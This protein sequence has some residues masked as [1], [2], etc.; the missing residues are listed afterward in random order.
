MEKLLKQIKGIDNMD[1]MNKVIN[2]IK[3]QRKIVK[4]AQIASFKSKF[5]VGDD[6]K[7][8]SS[9]NA[10]FIEGTVKRVKRTR[11][12]VHVELEGNWDVPLTMLEVA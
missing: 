5:S 1:D 7:F 10:G 2:A 6:V 11:A 12:I 9:R 3:K 4:N 8:W